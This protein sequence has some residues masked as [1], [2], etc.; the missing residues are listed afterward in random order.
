MSCLP[1]QGSRESRFAMLHWTSYSDR[2]AEW[3]W[4]GKL[5]DAKQMSVDM[6]I[7]AK[8]H[9]PQHISRSK[10]SWA[11]DRIFLGP[12]VFCFIA[13]NM[14]FVRLNSCRAE[15]EQTVVG[16]TENQTLQKQLKHT[17]PEQSWTCLNLASIDPSSKQKTGCHAGLNLQLPCCKKQIRSMATF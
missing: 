5:L 15:S 9:V 7:R 13:R 12:F 17:V 3:A 1:F 16:A 11:Y 4:P 2:E 10:T 6:I 14:F 8:M